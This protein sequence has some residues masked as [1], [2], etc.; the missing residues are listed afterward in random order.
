MIII[1]GKTASGKTTI[2]N[3]L[4]KNHGFHQIVTYTTR[5]IRPGEKQDETYHFISEEDFLSKIESGF[6][7]EYKVYNTA[8]GKWYY[9]SAKEDYKKADEKTLVI[10]T[11]DGYKDFIKLLPEVPS[12]AIYI[13][14][15][16][17]TIKN[18]LKKRGD[19]DEEIVRRMSADEHDFADATL[20]ADKVVYNNSDRGLDEVIQKVIQYAEGVKRK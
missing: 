7:L 15:N 4:V 2:V 11:P 14:S 20:L 6:F 12:T 3:E 19:N 5:P 8:F 1:F 10:L 9:G 17:S 18:R 13:F 16:R